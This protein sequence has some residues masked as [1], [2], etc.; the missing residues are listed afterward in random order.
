[1]ENLLQSIVLGHK[2]T[3][4]KL[5]EQTDVLNKI[6]DVQKNEL[7]AEQKRDRRE[8]QATKRRKADEAGDGLLGKMLGKEK[9]KGKGLLGTI[10]GGI[11]ALLTGLGGLGLVKAL[12]LGAIGAAIGAYF[13]NDKFRKFLNEKVFT[14]MGGFIKEGLLGSD[15]IFGK[16]NVEK[17]WNWIKD[18]PLKTLQSCCRLPWHC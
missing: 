12:G 1:M 17:T 11:G 9:K 4:K 5:E 2:D 8:A 15:G 16:K 3:Q 10:L 18:N 13:T 7:K 14:P 6:L